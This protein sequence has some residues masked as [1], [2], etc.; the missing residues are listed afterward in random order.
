MTKVFLRTIAL[1]IY[2]LIFKHIPSTNSAND[3]VVKIRI[4]LCKI[5]FKSVGSKVNIQKGVYFGKGNKISI[6]NYSGIG[7]DS[8]L[9]QA[10]EIII[11]ND[12]IIGQQLMVITQ[13][14]NFAIR[15]E[16]IR[17][18]GGITKSVKIENNVWI[19]ARVTILCGVTIGEG[20]II[21]AGSVVVK[22]IP[23]F[24]IAGGVPAKVI[25]ER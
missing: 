9:G 21:A 11:G 14:H 1:I 25:K 12:V 17:L 4:F 7:E 15:N 18:Q 19:G 13:N 22:N 16:L 8:R 20:S 5:I 10:D 3:P 6:G 24:S 2:Y 23:S